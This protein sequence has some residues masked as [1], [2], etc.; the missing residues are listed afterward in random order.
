MHVLVAY[1]SRHGST[2]G[3]AERIAETLRRAGLDAEARRV[4]EVKSVTGYD[5]LVI[6]S[7]AYMF[8]WEKAAT[9]F[10]RRHEKEIAARP[11]WLFSSGPTG[12]SLLDEQGRD[13]KVTLVP[14]EIPGLRAALKAR[15]HRVFFGAWD[16]TQKPVGLAERFMHLMPASAMDAM[17]VGDFRDWPEIEAWAGEIAGH[18]RRP[19][20]D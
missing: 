9:S 8:H 4:T 20:V 1:E 5:A 12:T 6:G 13:Q 17:P 11:T 18:L 2:R 7:A 15:D 3:I 10:V 14:K 16:P 19:A